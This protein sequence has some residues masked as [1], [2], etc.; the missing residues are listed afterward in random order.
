M[1]TAQQPGMPVAPDPA[2]QEALF[3]AA[4]SGDIDQIRQ[5]L[6]SGAVGINEVDAEGDG[7][8][9]WAA[10]KGQADACQTLAAAGAN[11]SLA[12]AAGRT[13]LHWAAGSGQVRVAAGPGP[14]SA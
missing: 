14:P 13:P 12:N 4:A 11:V 8:L 3:R 2:A 7:A 5:L 9:A 1:E 6:A 10:M